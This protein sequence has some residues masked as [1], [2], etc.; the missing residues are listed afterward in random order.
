LTKILLEDNTNPI[1]LDEAYVD[2]GQGIDE[3]VEWI[4]FDCRTIPHK[5][6]KG[7]T[8][9][10][11]KSWQEHVNVMVVREMERSRADRELDMWLKVCV[12]SGFL[13]FL[14]YSAWGMFT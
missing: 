12:V 2:L 4:A 1:G 3:S 5:T 13:L 11:L 6:K 9:V 10:R 14:Y 8:M 7:K